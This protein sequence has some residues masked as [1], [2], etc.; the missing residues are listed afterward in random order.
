M[1]FQNGMV[2]GGVPGGLAAVGYILFGLIVMTVVLYL[3]RNAKSETS[4]H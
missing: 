4:E 1:E 3:Q 2:S